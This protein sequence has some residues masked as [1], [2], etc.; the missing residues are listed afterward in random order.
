MA[1]NLTQGVIQVYDNSV[2]SINHALLRILEQLDS[3]RGLR[4]RTDLYDQ[5]TVSPPQQMNA[6]V[7][8]DNLS[9]LVSDI[10]D[11]FSAIRMSNGQSGAILEE[12][13]DA[14]GHDRL[15]A[16]GDPAFARALGRVGSDTGFGGGNVA[17]LVLDVVGDIYD[18]DAAGCVRHLFSS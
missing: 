16:L 12:E 1:N 14:A 18:K 9:A 13:V 2:E 17:S 8:L 3:L 6:A 5:A 4:G 7:R 11:P 15:A 10:S